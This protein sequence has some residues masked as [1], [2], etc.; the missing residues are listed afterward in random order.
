M[1]RTTKKSGTRAK[2]WTDDKELTEGKW[3]GRGNTGKELEETVEG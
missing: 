1:S 2:E 3:R